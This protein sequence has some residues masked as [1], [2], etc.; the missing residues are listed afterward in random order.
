MQLM[1]TLV[2]IA[3]TSAAMALIALSGSITLAL[4]EKTFGKVILPLM[5]VAAG[6]LLGGALSHL[7][8]RQ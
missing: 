5:A 4:P 2:W 7:L 3:A 8:P 6:S 1:A